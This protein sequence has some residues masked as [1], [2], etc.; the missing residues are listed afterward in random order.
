MKRLQRRKFLLALPLLVATPG[1]GCRATEEAP[2]KPQYVVV[3]LVNGPETASK[4]PEER[5]TIMA[6]HLA[7]IGRLADED[8]LL[9]AGPFVP[10]V[11]DD[12]LRGL[13]ILNTPDVET[14]RAWANTDPGVMEGVFALEF[15]PFRTAAPLRRSLDLYR[16]ESAELEKRGQKP[17]LGQRVRGYTLVLSHHRERV[18][19][20]LGKANAE[21]RMIFEGELLDSERGDFLGVLDAANVTEATK[22]LGEGSVEEQDLVAW[23][24][25]KAVAGIAGAAR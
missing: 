6:G 13:F 22:L 20:A 8:K 21:S 7:N 9:I 3:F 19:S 1:L 11:P 10:P 2:A 25:T 4:T 18:E 17:D 23:Y 16:A 14:A 5:Q 15:A 12:K 24:S